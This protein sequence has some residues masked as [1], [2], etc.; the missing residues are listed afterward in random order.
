MLKLSRWKAVLPE[1]LFDRRTKR[2]GESCVPLPTVAFWPSSWPS[3]PWLECFRHP[4]FG[5]LV[6]CQH[7]ELLLKRLQILDKIALLFIGK[8]KVETV[9][10]AVDDIQKG[11]EAPIVI[12]ASL[13]LRKEEETAFAHE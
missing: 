5:V 6:G 1:R 13:I 11:L 12:E 3:S 7:C 8:P 10:I 9:V 2:N 4:G